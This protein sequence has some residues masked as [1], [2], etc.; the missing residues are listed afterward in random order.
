LPYMPKLVISKI[1]FLIASPSGC[2]LTIISA[3][4]SNA[5]TLVKVLSKSITKYLLN[6]MQLVNC[7]KLTT[8]FYFANQSVLCEEN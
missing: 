4:T 7:C 8:G 2:S 6:F 5:S 1:F 3:K